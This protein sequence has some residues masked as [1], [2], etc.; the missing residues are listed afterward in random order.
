VPFRYTDAGGQGQT[1]DDASARKLAT[2]A[3]KSVCQHVSSPRDAQF[4]D[5]R[6]AFAQQFRSE[7]ACSEDQSAYPFFIGVFD[8]VAGLSDLGSLLV[9]A[10]VYLALLA[11]VSFLLQWLTDKSAGYWAAWFA[12]GTV[13]V[14][15]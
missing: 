11:A 12:L 1:A 6:N 15:G 10:G 8:T 9:L 7:H 5:Q 13:C 4:L 14:S 3:V 2:R